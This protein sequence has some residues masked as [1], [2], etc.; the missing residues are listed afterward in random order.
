MVN[1]ETIGNHAKAITAIFFAVGILAAFFIYIWT[2][3][4]RVDTLEDEVSGLVEDVRDANVRLES[5]D[6]KVG[7]LLCEVTNLAY[8]ETKNCAIESVE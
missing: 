4:G 3:P 6:R 5:V 2:L 8:E 1:L 7:V